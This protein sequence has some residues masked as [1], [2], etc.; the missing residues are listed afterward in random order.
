M[1]PP[2]MMKVP[3]ASDKKEGNLANEK[4]ILYD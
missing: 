4:H 1:T 3:R 2:Q